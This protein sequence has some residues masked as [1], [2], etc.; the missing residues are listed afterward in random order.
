G[1]PAGPVRASHA[2]DLLG[3]DLAL[4]QVLGQ[5]RGVDLGE[6]LGVGAGGGPPAAGRGDDAGGEPA[7][8][9]EEAG[10]GDHPVIGSDG[11]AFEVPAAHHGLPGD[12]LGPAAV[13]L[14]VLG[15]AGELGGRGHVGDEQAARGEGGGGHVDVLP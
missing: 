9:D 12:R 11:E 2:A 15:E 10:V 6:R 8:G 7:G 4:A 1:G 14:D 13:V 3:R 5:A